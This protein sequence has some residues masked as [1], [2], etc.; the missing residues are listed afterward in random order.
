MRCSLGLARG[1]VHIVKYR[2]R[3][4]SSFERERRRLQRHIGDRIVAIEHIG[5]TSVPGLS[6]KPIL[7]ISVGVRRVKDMR[8]IQGTLE[9]LGYERP[10]VGDRR[11]VLFAKGPD[12]RRTVYVHVM[13]YQGATW[14]NDLRF[15][16]WL[17]K[18][19][20]DRRRY[21]TLKERLAAIHAMDRAAYTEGKK[22]FIR[23]IIRK[24][25]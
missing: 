13:R 2:A 8:M 6:A 16:D 7:D 24:A 12:H 5:S 25:S 22:G 10:H 9:K 3:W 15:R 21:Q 1:T 17:R 4:P 23:N 14:R 19:P 11:N 18:H 20:N